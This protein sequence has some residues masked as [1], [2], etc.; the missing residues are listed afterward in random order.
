M[1]DLGQTKHGGVQPEGLNQIPQGL[2]MYAVRIVNSLPRVMLGDEFSGTDNVQTQRL[3]HIFMPNGGYCAYYPLNITHS[4]ENWGILPRCFPVLAGH[5]QSS[6]RDSL[7]PI[8]QHFNLAAINLKKSAY[9]TH[10]WPYRS[11]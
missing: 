5:I 3:E 9:T 8:T 7:R 1:P 6:V 10:S 4:F 11:R 2:N